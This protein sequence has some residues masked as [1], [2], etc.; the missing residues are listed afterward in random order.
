MRCP[1][2]SYVA[3]CSMQE[4]LCSTHIEYLIPMRLCHA[5]ASASRY[6]HLII[7]DD[8]AVDVLESVANF[9]MMTSPEPGI[10][11]AYQRLGKWLHPSN[12]TPDGLVRN[13]EFALYEMGPRQNSVTSDRLAILANVCNL[14]YTLS[15][16]ALRDLRV[17]YRTCLLVLTFANVW[18]DGVKRRA[19]YRQFAFHDTGQN[20][21]PTSGS[22]DEIMEEFI[23]RPRIDEDMEWIHYNLD[24]QRNT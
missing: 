1:L 11:S 13:I 2:T 15:T 20:T 5:S 17:S 8:L 7:H 10:L 4:K 19:K 22:T 23:H 24:S 21:T 6:Q 14:P 16:T 18:P 3:L 9:D 12:N